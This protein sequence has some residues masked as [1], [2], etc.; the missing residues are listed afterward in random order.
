MRR[1][2]AS[3][4]FTACMASPIPL[5]I[6]IAGP[7]RGRSTPVDASVSIGRDQQ[8]VLPIADPA[9]SRHHCVID[10]G[11]A[12]L[13][14]RDLGSKNGVFVNGCPVS[15]RALADGDQIRIGDS[16]LLVMLPGDAG[17]TG[18]PVVALVDTPMP[19]ASTVA[20]DARSSEYLS[21][22]REARDGRA[23]EGLRALLHFSE[24]LQSVQSAEA[25]Y[26]EVLT[27]AMNM[28][29]ADTAAIIVLPPGDEGLAVV[30]SKAP[31]GREVAVSR[32]LAARALHS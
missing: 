4:R 9:L 7:A 12:G 16:A 15:E 6:V 19:A 25:L 22:H 26:R 14:L 17:R 1:G 27:H 11:A 2:V 21:A 32:T 8:N 5:L 10:R 29:R 24:S 20:I 13:L 31:E 28:F 3:S 30:C 18:A 23:T